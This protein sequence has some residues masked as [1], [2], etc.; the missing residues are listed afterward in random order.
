MDNDPA[1]MHH[2]LARVS[3]LLLSLS[4]VTASGERSLDRSE[5]SPRRGTRKLLESRHRGDFRRN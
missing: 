5:H 2:S 1:I 3:R 4:L